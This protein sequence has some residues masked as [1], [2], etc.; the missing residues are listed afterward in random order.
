MPSHSRLAI[1]ARVVLLPLALILLTL[2]GLGSYYEASD[3]TTL[4]W[5]FSGVLS[6][7]PITSVPLYFH[8]YGHLLAAAYTAAPGVPWLGLLLS[9]LLAGA[10]ILAFAVLDNLLR[11][12]LRPPA[13]VL[14]LVVFF[15][16]AWVEH[17]LW[18]SYVRVALLLAGVAVLYAAQRPGHRGA[19]LLGLA[20]L[21]AAW[22]LRPSQAALGLGAVL[23]AVLLLAGGGRRALPV[24]AGAAFIL[25]FATGAAALLRT[26]EQAHAQVRDGYFARVLDF[27]Q[28]RPQPRTAAD[29]LGTDAVNLWLMGDSTVVNEAMCRRAYHFDAPDFFRQVVPAKLVLRAQLLVRDYFPLLLALLAAAVG[30]ARRGRPGWFW[31]VQFGFVGV[32][33]FLAGVLKLPARI[34]LPLLDFWLLTNLA[35]LFQA[36]GF[37]VAA[38]GAKPL[39]MSRPAVS[40]LIRRLSVVATVLVLLLY[41]A[42]TWHRHQVLSQERRHHELALQAITRL[43]AGRLRI[44]GGTNDLLKSLSPFRNYSAG[45]GPV[46]LLT[47]WSSHDASQGPL[48]YALSG[49]ADQTDC[50][51]RL[52]TSAPAIAPLWVLTPESAHWL[53]RRFRF[54]GAPRLLLSAQ[55][56]DPVIYADAA[57]FVYRVQPYPGP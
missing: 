11:P 37:S 4:A 56:S 48:R 5:L 23:P 30:V 3:D 8:G 43:E 19:L 38:A 34:E 20:G 29:S 1:F 52:V 40:P 39:V 50:L 49:H 35:F 12:H 51:R 13:L 2:A 24:V 16:V 32:F 22:L 26:P 45:P 25:A 36:A 10:T 31:L 17:W 7:K 44:L 55:A 42:K 53:S 28:L 54:G 15:G 14:A 47:G 21:G 6:L 9:T 27:D 18:F 57:L 46:L 41:G 33:V